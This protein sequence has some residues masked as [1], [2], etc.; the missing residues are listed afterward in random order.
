MF[1][2]V[3]NLHEP[4]KKRKSTNNIT[5]KIFK[6]YYKMHELIIILI[7]NINKSIFNSKLQYNT[8]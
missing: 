7:N 8:N 2:F 4:L 3:F 6:K 5:E 1:F